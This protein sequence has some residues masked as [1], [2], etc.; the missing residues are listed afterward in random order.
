MLPIIKAL[1]RITT[2]KDILSNLMWCLLDISHEGRKQV[3]AILK[4]GIAKHVLSAM[5]HEDE[6]LKTLA[7]EVA[8]NILA[9]CDQIVAVMVAKGVI[10]VLASLLNDPN[11]GPRL[12][13]CRALSNILAGNARIIKEVFD[14]EDGL[15]IRKLF[16]MIRNDHVEVHCQILFSLTF[17]S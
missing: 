2:K 16:S 6:H 4:L 9:R 13:A 12:S 8:V 3:A 10:P 1:L 11:H 7:T 15:I 5:M 14:Y 17:Y